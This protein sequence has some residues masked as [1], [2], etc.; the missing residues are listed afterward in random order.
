[1]GAQGIGRPL[2]GAA[3]TDARPA[4][5][6]LVI[7]VK[8]ALAA[9]A[10]ELGRAAAAAGAAAGAPAAPREAAATALTTR[11]QLAAGWQGERSGLWQDHS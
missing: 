6:K 2:I 7:G 5:D 4:G 9:P 3:A 10:A 1:M 11:P 8:T